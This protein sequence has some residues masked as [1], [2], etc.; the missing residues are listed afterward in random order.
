MLHIL[1]AL[2]RLETKID[3]FALYGSALAPVPKQR[4]SLDFS[5]TSTGAP[6]K[7]HLTIPH[8]VI[9]WPAIYLHLIHSGIQATTDLQYVLQTGT[10]WLIHHEIAKHP[11][12]LPSDIKLPTVPV[13]STNQAGQS[14]RLAFPTLT[15]DQIQK[16][17]HAY[18]NTFNVLYPILDQDSFLTDVGMPL[19][20]E[21][22]DEGDPNAILALLVYAL[23]QVALEGVLGPPIRSAG[24]M[25][26][27]LRGGSLQE[28]PGIWIFNEARRR[29]GFV[30][31]T[32][33][34]ENVQIQML[35]AIY[36]EANSRHLD[37]WQSIVSASMACQVL[38]RCHPIEWTSREGDM[39]RRAFWACALCETQYH[40]DLDLPET[41]IQA[42]EDTVPVPFSYDSLEQN[43]HAP[44]RS[45]MQ[46]HFLA[47]LGLR[48]L[49]AS[50]N[51]TIL[52]RPCRPLSFCIYGD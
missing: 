44:E 4:Q 1:D 30:V 36:Y 3:N 29:L 43:G 25:P 41:G 33:S 35:Q 45:H 9:T 51:K 42:L 27:G 6:P 39:I 34:I 38:V 19:L 48:R 15:V 37:F 20:R 21:G 32:C 5:Q 14:A 23:G 2:T 13:G 7:D 18:F 50:I 10:P 31:N 16:L 49:I 22:Y 8:R 24:G 40:L 52:E 26:S 17:S 28:P 46:Y 11:L 12:L 47:M